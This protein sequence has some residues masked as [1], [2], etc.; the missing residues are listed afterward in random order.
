M[1]DKIQEWILK[2]KSK[3][4]DTKVL[5]CPRCRND[6]KIYQNTLNAGRGSANFCPNCGL[7][8]K[9]AEATE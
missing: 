2:E 6:F 8:L 4:F 7:R 1:S 9:E 5:K 3:L